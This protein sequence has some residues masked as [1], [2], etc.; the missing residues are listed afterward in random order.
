MPTPEL[1]D[2]GQPVEFLDIDLDKLNELVAGLHSLVERQRYERYL[3]FHPYDKQLAFMKAGNSYRERLL[4]A[5]NQVG[6]T[7]IG[8]YE[9]SLHLT[10]KYPDWWEG[11]R[12]DHPVII[13]AC[14]ET[15]ENVRDTQQRYLC[16]T[17][18]V[19]EDFGTGMIPLADFAD[20]PSLARGVTDFFDT[21]HVK[22]YRKEGGEW[23]QDGISSCKFK[24]YE[25]GRRK[26]QSA[27]LDAVWCDEEPPMDIYSE[28]LT[29]ITATRGIV[30][31]T[32]TP[33]QG[34]SDVIRRYLD[35]PSPDRTVVTMTIED[36]KHIDPEE[37][38]RIIAGYPSHE[39]DARSKGVPMLGSGRIFPY[40]D[41]MI[42]EDP[43]PSDYLPM[44]W[45]KLW[46]C[47][48]GIEHPFA[49]VLIAWDVDTDTIH[50]LNG[51][52]IQGV[53]GPLVHATAMKPIGGNVWVAWPH[54]GNE[55]DVEGEDLAY[56]YRKAG[57][58]MRPSHATWASGG[59]G[60]EVGI[61]EMDERMR[62]G[63]L[64]VNRLFMPWFEEFRMY[65]RKDG[66]I[67]KVQDDIMSAT[68]IAIMDKRYAQ[69]GP[70]GPDMKDRGKRSAD[71][72]ASGVDF[73]LW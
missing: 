53:E 66:Q 72:M 44:E 22:H 23:V 2:D 47:D 32:F 56:K 51:I 60:T 59:Y 5:A 54:D 28:I 27:T 58:R 45:K 41:D 15:G 21:I 68:R 4:M 3:S 63:K 34:W 36:A 19:E 67:V 9:T 30:F 70:I 49:A 64:K 57:L 42:A 25:Q 6:K 69:P 13:W 24:T 35:E 31:V 18:G 38:D 55:R 14:G 52:R 50:I 61:Y 46:G 37:R 48:F 11:R 39:R 10:G 7:A 16:G 71:G 65:H 26:F 17:P 1:D 29:R 40:A 43:I 33:L 12:F 73:D 62:T 20:K 8:A